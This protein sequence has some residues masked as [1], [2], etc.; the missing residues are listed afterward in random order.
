MEKKEINFKVALSENG[1]N[2]IL[3]LLS[4][5][6]LTAL[7]EKVITVDDAET[8]LFLPKYHTLAERLNL[9]EGLRDIILD[10]LCFD[11]L[12]TLAHDEL[13]GSVDEVKAKVLNIINELDFS[14][15]YLDIEHTAYEEKN[16]EKFMVE[17]GEVDV[18]PS[19]AVTLLEEALSKSPTDSQL[20]YRLG[21]E[22]TKSGNYKRAMAAVT[23]AITLNP[24]LHIAVFLLGLIYLAQRQLDQAAQTWAP[25][26]TLPK[27]DPLRWFSAM[28]Q[29]YLAKNGYTHC[30]D[31]ERVLEE[32][33]ALINTSIET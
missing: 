2:Y 26:V 20:Y 25:L 29:Q 7:R 18:T 21:V 8:L 33:E 6:I 32:V 27:K 16:I 14:E 15:N 24:D 3:S 19:K 5:G 31:I 11:G 17:I 30:I 4:L 22:Y 13:D 12:L 1:C 23:Q 28:I 10:G 9:H